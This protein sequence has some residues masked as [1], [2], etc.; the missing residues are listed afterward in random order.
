MRASKYCSTRERTLLQRGGPADRVVARRDRDLAE[1]LACG[2]VEVHMPL[3]EHREHR[4][5]RHQTG[6]LDEVA[7]GRRWRA[8]DRSRLAARRERR[9]EAT[10]GLLQR[11]HRHDAL[12]HA[13]VNRR[14]GEPDRTGGA[15]S[16]P[17][18]HRGE[19]HVGY[20]EPLRKQ[21]RVEPHAVQREPVE[22][23]DREAGI[24]E[25]RDHGLA[26]ELHRRLRQRLSAPVVRRRADTHHGGLILQR[27][28]F[29]RYNFAALPP[30]IA[31]I[32]SSGMPWKMRSTTS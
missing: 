17:G 3:R 20:A 23:V 26:R 12:G 27:H 15:P 7:L 21:R 24:G 16:S 25:G 8:V 31:S 4:T 1:V 6:W 19:P 22:V 2:A 28:A 30:T 29:T 9:A 14:G 13:R 10:R 5:R 18:E 32:S 11:H